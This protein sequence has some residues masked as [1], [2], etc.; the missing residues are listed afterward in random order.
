MGCRAGCPSHWQRCWKR[1][2]LC[3]RG[4]SSKSLRASSLRSWKRAYWTP[5]CH[6]G[7]S[8][9]SRA[10]TCTFCT[11]YIVLHLTLYMHDRAAITPQ[12]ASRLL[13]ICFISSQV[14]V[15]NL[16]LHIHIH[17]I[18]CRMC[19]IMRH[20]LQQNVVLEVGLENLL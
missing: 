6:T 16:A 8:S 11:S 10:D 20:I 3:R 15:C 5:C 1:Q 12:Q 9:A 13:R 4:R 18:S 19:L 7:L 14:L 17:G 2:M